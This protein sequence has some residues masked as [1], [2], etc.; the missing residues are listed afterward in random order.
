MVG[1]SQLFQKNSKIHGTIIK[2]FMTRDVRVWQE[3]LWIHPTL[4]T[5]YIIHL[6]L[7]LYTVLATQILRKNFELHRHRNGHRN[8]TMTNKCQAH[9]FKGVYMSLVCLAESKGKTERTDLFCKYMGGRNTREGEDLKL[10]DS[11]DTRIK[12]HKLGR[13]KFRLKIR[14]F[15]SFRVGKV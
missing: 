15:L 1:S 13:N 11:A 8:A 12:R 14:M 7:L 4:S 6:Q 9:H 10:K 2:M 5:V 3:I